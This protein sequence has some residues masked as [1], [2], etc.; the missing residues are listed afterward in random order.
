VH[1]LRSGDVV[2]DHR[3]VFGALG[4]SIEI[5]HRAS[6]RDIFAKGALEAATWVAKAKPGLYS[7]LDVL[8]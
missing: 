3:V 2:G 4:D 1:A 5:I 7:M 8:G 6:S